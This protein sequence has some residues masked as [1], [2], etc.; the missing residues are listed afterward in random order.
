MDLTTAPLDATIPPENLGRE[1]GQSPNSDDMPATFPILNL[2][3]ELLLMIVACIG[4]K[5]LL[6]LRETCKLLCRISNNSFIEK[7]IKD[8]GVTVSRTSLQALIDISKHTDFASHVRTINIDASCTL[9]FV[10]DINNFEKLTRS[11]MIRK[12]E[13]L[14]L[15]NAVFHTADLISFLSQHRQTL[16][17]LWLTECCVVKMTGSWTTIFT[18]IRNNLTLKNFGVKHLSQT[19]LDT[20]EPFGLDYFDE[21][22]LLGYAEA[23]GVEEVQ[24]YLDDAIAALS[25]SDL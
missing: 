23:A 10:L 5:T 22:G 6:A 2:P 17:K 18:W 12:L 7:F 13:D 15:A 19:Y 8:L 14:E 4:R 16:K 1:M 11:L 24:E 25:D 21:E 20:S 3:D 9:G